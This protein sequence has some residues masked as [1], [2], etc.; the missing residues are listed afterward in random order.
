MKPI[1]VAVFYSLGLL[2]ATQGLAAQVQQQFSRTDTSSIVALSYLIRDMQ[3]ILHPL[4]FRLSQMAVMES[5]Q[6]FRP[7]DTGE[8]RAEAEEKAKVL[9]QHL[10]ARLRRDYPEV[11][12]VIDGKN[13][14]R[15]RVGMPDSYESQ[16][17]A[18]FQ[19]S[20]ALQI[21]RIKQRFPGSDIRETAAGGYSLSAD[22][23]TQLTQIKAALKQAMATVQAEIEQADDQERLRLQQ[24]SQRLNR[25]VETELRRLNQQMADF[26]GDYFKARWYR[27]HKENSLL[28]DYAAIAR[29]SLPG[30]KPL[31]KPLQ[32]WL[33]G[34]SQRDA[35][36][37]LLLFVQGIPYDALQ[38]RYHDAGFLTPLS[39]LSQNRGDCDSKSVLTAALLHHLYPRM[40]IAML[41]LDSHALLAL[42]IP[43]ESGDETVYQEY[44]RW[45]LAEPVGPRVAG[46]GQVGD[47]YQANPQIE[48]FI[49]MF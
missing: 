12:F 7:L 27:E 46:L 48:A 31:L 20:L 16:R 18:L 23:Q 22:S 8:M 28:P 40:K 29:V 14:I 6:L 32:R 17:K 36:E 10:V 49:R 47:E 30:L 45:V 35:I 3:G 26:Q 11:E 34:L 4:S 21:A 25:Q 13:S 41:V 9:T 43:V 5:E 37:R 38:N 19:R 2:L 44:R 24:R 33:Q 39:V 15:T 1:V 42:H